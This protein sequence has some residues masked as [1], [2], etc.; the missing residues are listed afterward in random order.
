MDNKNLTTGIII[1][2]IVVAVTVGSAYLQ[3][4]QPD[5]SPNKKNTIAREQ[6]LERYN[7]GDYSATGNYIS[8]GGAEE[9]GVTITLEDNVIIESEVEIRAEREISLEM[10]T[11]FSENYREQVIGKNIDEVELTKVSGSSLTPQGFNDAL[12]KVRAQA[13]S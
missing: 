11:D 4:I 5:S 7:D 2:I 12:E 10:Q 9:I 1:V 3:K 6:I 8:P 13:K